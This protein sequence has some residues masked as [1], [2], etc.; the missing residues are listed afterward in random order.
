M[1]VK[2]CL[3]EKWIAYKK[4]LVA[5]IKRK[6]K[7]KKSHSDYLKKIKILGSFS[8]V[9]M[10][11]IE[12]QR[13]ILETS[14]PRPFF[15]ILLE[16]GE[17]RRICSIGFDMMREQLLKTILKAESKL[18]DDDDDDDEKLMKHAEEVIRQYEYLVVKEI[19]WINSFL[20]K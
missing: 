17:M 13:E 10:E 4:K 5:W 8:N 9:S 16:E 14:A 18:K 2:Q 20:N 6:E 19:G 1:L 3:Q 11:D 15:K 12:R 7:A